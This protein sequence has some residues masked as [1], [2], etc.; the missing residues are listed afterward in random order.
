MEVI[1]LEAKD[2]VA[3]KPRIQKT[4][5]DESYNPMPER[6]SEAILFNEIAPSEIIPGQPRIFQTSPGE[7][8]AEFIVRPHIPFSKLIEIWGNFNRN[9]YE[10]ICSA[11]NERINS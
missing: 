4:Y 7:D 6:T 9:L 1:K 2:I 11:K 5:V 3:G 10:Q 8:G